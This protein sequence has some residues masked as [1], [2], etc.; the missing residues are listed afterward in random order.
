MENAEPLV[1]ILICTYNRSAWLKRAIN[2]V[3]A[4]DFIHFELIIID[5]C[6][7]DDTSAVVNAYKD[8][9]IRYIRN[10]VNV[11]S[12]QG[13]RAHIR[14]FIYELMRGQYFIYLCDDDYWP[15]STL[16]R[17]QVEAF[18]THDNVAMIISGQL[19][20]TTN[21]E[22]DPLPDLE[23]IPQVDY[24]DLYKPPFPKSNCFIKHL[25][26]KFFMTSEEFLTDFSENPAARNLIVGATLYSK[27]H[28]TLAE[29]MSTSAGPKWQAGYELLM[30][31]ACYFTQL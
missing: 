24:K 19:H 18:K 1:S 10:E 16:L 29:I 26:P 15:R 11:G 25:F 21:S 12:I 5:D 27:R 4:Q 2:S 9:R 8:E 28:F 14:R 7:S 6:S 3:L 23:K 22:N 20:H 17:R 31:P 13:D 30:G